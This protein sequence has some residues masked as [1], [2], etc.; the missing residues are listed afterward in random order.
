MYVNVNTVCI[1]DCVVNCTR[2]LAINMKFLL[3]QTRGS[4]YIGTEVEDLYQQ[5]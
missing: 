3:I 4:P 1:L 2:T 5:R